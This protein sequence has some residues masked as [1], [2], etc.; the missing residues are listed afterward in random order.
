MSVVDR[1]IQQIHA[2]RIGTSRDSLEAVAGI[3]KL[4]EENKRTRHSGE[5]PVGRV[6]DLKVRYQNS[7]LS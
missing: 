7:K 2:H 4:L 1:C 6:R 3:T 5:L